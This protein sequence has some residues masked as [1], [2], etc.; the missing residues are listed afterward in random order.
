MLVEGMLA[1]LAL[2]KAYRGYFLRGEIPY[3]VSGCTSAPWNC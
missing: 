2:L 1:D 3:N